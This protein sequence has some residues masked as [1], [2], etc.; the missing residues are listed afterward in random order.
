MSWGSRIL[1]I[2]A[3]VAVVGAVWY[4]AD[5][6]QSS[7]QVSQQNREIVDKTSNFRTV[8][9]EQA[10]TLEDGRTVTCIL[11]YNVKHAS[12]TAE[13]KAINCLASKTD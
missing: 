4:Y 5:H 10:I 11:A 2:A 1:Q 7:S 8:L 12:G 9:K 13:V 6:P 3:L